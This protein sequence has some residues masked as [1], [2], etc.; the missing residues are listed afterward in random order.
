MVYRA[1]FKK[2]YRSGLTHVL[3]PAVGVGIVLVSGALYGRYS[4]R[5]GP[6]AKL[7]EA[8]SHVESLPDMLGNWRL[9]E[10]RAMQESAL[11]M[12]ECAG[13]VNRQYVHQK[14]GQT[15]SVAV[16]VGPAGPTAVHTPEI[17]FSSRAYEIQDDRVPIVIEAASGSQHSFWRVDF[18]TRNELADGLRVYYAWSLGKRWQASDSPRFEFAAAPMLYKVQVAAH[19]EPDL[20]SSKHE[21]CRQF[22]EDLVNS[23]WSLHTNFNSAL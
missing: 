11:A 18:K 2:A 7:A 8:G 1:K 16:I 9:V 14:S 12:L 23:D 3:V 15:I 10:D 21:P 19:I 20:D 4:Q 13:Y 6:P 22:L 5:W 17:C